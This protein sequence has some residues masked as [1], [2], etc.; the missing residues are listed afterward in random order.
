MRGR[1][2]KVK[3]RQAPQTFAVD[4]P[5]RCAALIAEFVRRIFKGRLSITKAVPAV[6]T[7][8][9]AV[10]KKGHPG[11]PRTGAR[12]V[13]RKDTRSRSGNNQGFRFR[14]KT[15]RDAHRLVL[16]SQE[17]RFA[18]ERINEDASESRGGKGE[19]MAAAHVR[20]VTEERKRGTPR[21]EPGYPW[22]K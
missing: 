8:Q 18:V 5:R 17:S 4:L 9:L 7:S 15:Q 21:E 22:Y 3:S 16:C 11:F 13:G 19:K 12:L 2:K 6:R 14:E 1:R 10:N 20:S